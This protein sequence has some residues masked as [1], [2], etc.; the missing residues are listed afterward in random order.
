MSGVNVS[1]R[2]VK[3][4]YTGDLYDD[5]SESMHDQL[6]GI[7]D[8]WPGWEYIEILRK[9]HGADIISMITG[10]GESCGMGFVGPALNSMATVVRDD[11]ASE[12]LSF[13]HESKC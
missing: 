10:S 6:Y 3:V 2:L 13:A 1:L 9:Q 5:S 8:G 12:Y 11:C 7:A 4:Q